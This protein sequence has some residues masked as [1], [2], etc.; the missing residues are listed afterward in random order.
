MPANVGP[1]VAALD[2]LTASE[3][4][5]CLEIVTAQA[6]LAGTEHLSPFL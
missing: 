5:Q 4:Q 6:Q 2:N 3:L 1:V